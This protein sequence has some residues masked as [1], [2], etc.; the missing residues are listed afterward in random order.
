RV[1]QQPGEETPALGSAPVPQEEKQKMAATSTPGGANVAPAA[2][3]GEGQDGP[4]L[5]E[6]MRGEHMGMAKHW[7][8]LAAKAME[9]GDHESY[10]HC[11]SYA[12]HHMKYGATASGTG[13]ELDD[14]L[15]NDPKVANPPPDH[16]PGV[17]HMET[18]LSYGHTPVP[19]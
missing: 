9:R 12:A 4:L 1:E 16:G 14:R 7:H 10:R 5:P 19:V 18:H 11:M 2:P 17:D 15:E 13:G 8:K 6:D 3:M